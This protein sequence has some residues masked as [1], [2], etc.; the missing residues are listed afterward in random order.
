MYEDT[1]VIKTI[2]LVSWNL[3]SKFEDNQ[4]ILYIKMI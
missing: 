4:I 2:S 1:I 3:E